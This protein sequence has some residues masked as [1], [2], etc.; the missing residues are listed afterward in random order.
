MQL[1]NLLSEGQPPGWRL[2]H[3]GDSY[4]CAEGIDPGLGWP[5]VLRQLLAQRGIT[6]A[7]QHIV[8][9]T[10]WTASE[11]LEHLLAAPPTAPCDLVTL[12]IGVNNQYRGLPIEP[13]RRDLAA[14]IDVAR[15]YLL[16]T[17]AANI[18]V[19]SIPD[20]SV[21]PCAAAMNRPA[22]AGAIDAFNAACR[23]TACQASVHWVDWTPLSRS[24]L[25]DVTAFAADGLHP[26]AAQ[27]A[28][29]ALAVGEWITGK[30][31]E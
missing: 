27:H 19:L 17:A 4:T 3:L 1:R 18:V 24:F 30:R 12:C 10:G 22:I 9:R 15:R 25:D 11:L 26:S 6:V 23:Q 8:A 31:M 28:A 16:P 20:Y 5:A 29:W 21:A 14:L 7:H 13:F 2:L